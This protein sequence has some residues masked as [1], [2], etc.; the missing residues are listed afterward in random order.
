M[1]GL[2]LLGWTAQNRALGFGRQNLKGSVSLTKHHQQAKQQTALKR[3]C[4]RDSL[5]LWEI[6][7][8]KFHSDLKVTDLFIAAKCNFSAI[9]DHHVPLLSVH[10]DVSR[11]LVLSIHWRPRKCLLSLEI[12]YKSAVRKQISFDFDT[13][14]LSSCREHNLLSCPPEENHET[15]Q[16]GVHFGCCHQSRLGQMSSVS[17][18][19]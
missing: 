11:Q 10:M 4:C 9:T 8:P 3:H 13:V 15:K 1:S 5:L 2:I 16:I 18:H 7:P 17:E 6:T 12:W 19:S 14:E